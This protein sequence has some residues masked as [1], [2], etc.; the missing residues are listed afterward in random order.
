MFYCENGLIEIF[1][2]WFSLENS[3]NVI[4]I[5]PNTNETVRFAEEMFDYWR[6]SLVP[7]DVNEEL[8]P[9]LEFVF[10]DNETQ[11]ESI[12]AMTDLAKPVQLAVVFDDDPF[13]NMSVHP[14]PS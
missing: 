8:L 11:L 12:Y 4:Y 7:V 9:S 5:V 1:I 3:T 14:Y 6:E 2:N 10:L 13:V